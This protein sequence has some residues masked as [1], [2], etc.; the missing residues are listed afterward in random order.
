MSAALLRV[1]QSFG[2]VVAAIYRTVP[3][4]WVGVF[5]CGR[6]FSEIALATSIL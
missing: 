1:A 6:D 2:E 4:G 3:S 5:V